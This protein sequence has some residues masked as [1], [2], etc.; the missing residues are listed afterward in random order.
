MREA[1]W[2]VASFHDWR[3]PNE[4]FQDFAR[5]WLAVVMIY[6]DG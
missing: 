1:S 6:L 2:I 5:R 4:V 3:S